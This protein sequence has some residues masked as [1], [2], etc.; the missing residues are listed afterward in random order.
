[1]GA[2]WGEI[3][4]D[5]CFVLPNK[6]VVLVA[7]NQARE[8]MH[9]LVVCLEGSHRKSYGVGKCQQ[10]TLF[11][12]PGGEGAGGSQSLYNCLTKAGAGGSRP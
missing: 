9:L 4:E 6:I 7:Q 11:S 8:G 3:I 12:A 1:M 10:K 2:W 5:G